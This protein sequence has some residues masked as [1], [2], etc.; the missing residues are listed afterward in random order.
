MCPHGRKCCGLSPPP[1]SMQNLVLIL[2]DTQPA[3]Q[4]YMKKK[5]AN[6]T[7]TNRGVCAPGCQAPC[8]APHRAPDWFGSRNNI[9]PTITPVPGN[10]SVL[11]RPE[12]KNTQASARH[13]RTHAQAA[14]KTKQKGSPVITNVTPRA[15]P[16]R[17]LCLTPPPPS[18]A[19]R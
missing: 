15:P 8:S 9:F 18:P 1:N 12:K 16:L 2:S 13:A 3:G 7:E 17:H 5:T 6:N 11:Q 14:Q 19:R 4:V 10:N